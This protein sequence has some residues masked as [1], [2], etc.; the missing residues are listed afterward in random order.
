MSFNAIRDNFNFQIY[1]IELNVYALQV[2]VRMCCIF[3]PFYNFVF[4]FFKFN[5]NFTGHIL[6]RIYSS[7]MFLKICDVLGIMNTL[8]LL[9]S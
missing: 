1:S 6:K 8:G 9:Q 5:T 7:I 3:N 4:T 2:L